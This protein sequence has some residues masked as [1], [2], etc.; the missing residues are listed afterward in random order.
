MIIVIYC[1][2]LPELFRS[3]GNEFNDQKDND[4]HTDLEYLPDHFEKELEKSPKIFAN[5]LIILKTILN[6]YF[7]NYLQV[8]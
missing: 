1:N 2:Y 7:L 5:V 8:Q 3:L 4:G 6:V